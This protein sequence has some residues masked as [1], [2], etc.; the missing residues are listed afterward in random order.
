MGLLRDV[1]P[2]LWRTFNAVSAALFI[3]SSGVLAERAL[4]D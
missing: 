1:R 2:V 3:E 4:R